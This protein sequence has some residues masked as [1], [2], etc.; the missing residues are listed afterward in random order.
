VPYE[1]SDQALLTRSFVAHDTR[2]S[3]N[4]P[5]RH[6]VLNLVRALAEHR[7]EATLQR[8]AEPTIRTNGSNYLLTSLT[9]FI[10]HEPCIMCSMA[11]LHSRVREVIYIVPAPQTGGCGGVA[12]VPRMPGVNHRFQIGRWKLEGPWF[13]WWATEGVDADE[14]SDA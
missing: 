14:N 11:L 3:N 5:L 9:L 7:A 12:C 1:A 8:S 2:R 6:A 10:T 13:E 4:H